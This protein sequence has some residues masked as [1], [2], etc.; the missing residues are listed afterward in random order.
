MKFAV[1]NMSCGHCVASITRAL[2]ALDPQAEVRVDL[3]A[4]TV[5]VEGRIDSGQAV[6]AMAAEGYPARPLAG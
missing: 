4:A 2:R 5:E 3:A 6:A 1:D